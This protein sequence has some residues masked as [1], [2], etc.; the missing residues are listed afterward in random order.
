MTSTALTAYESI[1][2]DP[3][4]AL[5]FIDAIGD[6]FAKGGLVGC[7]TPG[8]GKMLALTCLLDGI[9]PLEFVRTY[10]LVDGKPTMRADAMLGKFRQ[11]GGKVAWKNLADDGK[12]AVAEFTFEGQSQ[13]VRYTIEDAKRAGLVKEK[14]GW[15]KDPGAMLRARLASK[16]V[17]IMAPEIV[18]GVY[19]PEELGD[20]TQESTGSP[21]KRAKPADKPAKEDSGEV[22]DAEYEVVDE[23]SADTDENP[24]GS[25]A[26]KDD[27][28]IDDVPFDESPKAEK[29]AA[30]AVE[31]KAGNGRRLEV[32]TLV[33]SNP[34][35]RDYG[36]ELLKKL[37]VGAVSGLSEVQAAH[38]AVMLYTRLLN[39]DDKL[40][41]ALKKFDVAKVTE[42]DL[43][44]AEKFLSSL[45]K[46]AK[47]A[48][49]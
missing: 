18:A 5:Q 26:P 11:A 43:D 46:Q 38:M 36:A 22:V 12:E 32:R 48:G 17:R 29:P 4:A 21:K 28:D 33:G 1:G 39:F 13:V 45:R 7:K 30:S 8:Q 10:H 25:P 14:S 41:V 15:D 20:S 40:K 9:T 16:A 44:T 49:K 23:S 19:T 42:L 2:S 35:L 3:Q 24:F 6:A 31:S 34:E 27:A 37:G 47:A